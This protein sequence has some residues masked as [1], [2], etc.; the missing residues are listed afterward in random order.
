MEASIGEYVDMLIVQD[1]TERLVVEVDLNEAQEGDLVEYILPPMQAV[2][3]TETQE[4][5]RMGMVLKKMVC[6]RGG[7]DWNCFAEL[8]P[9]RKG[10]TVYHHTWSR[11]T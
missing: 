8:A 2:G 3:F 10:K 7:N 1:G 5:V 6:Q 4:E 9:I 11:D